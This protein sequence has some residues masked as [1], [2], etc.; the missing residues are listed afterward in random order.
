MLNFPDVNY[1]ITIVF[2]Q[3][4]HI[5]HWVLFYQRPLQIWP[6]FLAGL[7]VWHLIKNF[8]FHTVFNKLQNLEY[9]ETLQG[10]FT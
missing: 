5:G 2:V 7:Y 10:L 1:E 4:L 9:L 6:I 8:V 3:M